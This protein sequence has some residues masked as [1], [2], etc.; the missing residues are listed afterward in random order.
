M[1]EKDSLKSVAYQ[2]PSFSE[3]QAM[4]QSVGQSGSPAETSRSGGLSCLGMG[5]ALS[6]F[7]EVTKWPNDIFG[8]A[9]YGSIVNC[10]IRF[11]E[12]LAGISQHTF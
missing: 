9:P 12:H 3:A 10:Y 5:S 8:N 1:F 2:R 11:K 6:W 7:H 4:E